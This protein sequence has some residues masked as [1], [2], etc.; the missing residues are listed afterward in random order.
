M[1][2][3][4]GLIKSHVVKKYWMALTGLFLCLFLVGHLLGNLQLFGSGY[5]GR[6]QFNEYAV[7]MTTNPA[8]Q[9]LSYLTYFSILFHAVDGLMLTIANRKARP[10]NYAYNKPSANSLWSSRNMGIL[11]TVI[12]VYIVVHMQNFWYEYKFG[13]TPFMYGENGVDPLLKDGTVVQ[14]GAIENGEVVFE[15]QVLGDAMRDLYTV[16][17]DGFQNP[18]LVAFYVLGMIAIAF[19]LVHGFQSGFQSLG[20]RNKKYS[21]IITKLGYA[22]AIIVPTL[23]AIIPVYMLLAKA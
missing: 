13:K 19:H 3:S 16:V 14:G 9:I 21:P 7:F 8:V 1:S 22:F 2:E 23:F 5:E 12:L 15:G 17:L 10:K 11:G 20:L 6:L 18:I 4:K